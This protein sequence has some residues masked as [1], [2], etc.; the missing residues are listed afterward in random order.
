MKKHYDRI[1]ASIDLDAI[2][3]NMDNIANLLSSNTKILSV[4]K[5]DGYGHG[6]VPI[7]LELEEKEYMYGFATA[8]AE[9]AFVLRK[10][11]IQKPIL[12]LGYVFPYTYSQMIQEDIRLT[13]FRS[14]SHE[15]K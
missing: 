8:T 6:S 10:A 2:S 3:H 5:T 12:V 14:R 11:G 1:F 13:V 4:V 9:E 15:I 7:A